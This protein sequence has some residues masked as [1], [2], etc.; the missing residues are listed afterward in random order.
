MDGL[1]S[2]SFEAACDLPV[3][4]LHRGKSNSRR[5][6]SCPIHLIDTRSRQR[7]SASRRMRQEVYR[8]MQDADAGF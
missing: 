2:R 8:L 4:K 7:L 3:I 6:D 5:F 1:D